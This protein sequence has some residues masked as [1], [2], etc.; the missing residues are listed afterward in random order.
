MSNA[1]WWAPGAYEDLRSLDAPGFAWEYLLRNP[2][3]LK[4]RDR[5]DRSAREGVLGEAERDAFA[6]RWGVR[7]CEHGRDGPAMSG[8]LGGT[9]PAKCG[10][11]DEAP[12]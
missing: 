6:L 12:R 9:C 7:F 8:P 1:D 11:S 3:F 2:D 4:H 5:L 10:R